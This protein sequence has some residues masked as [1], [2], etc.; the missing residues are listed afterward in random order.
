[1]DA[2]FSDTFN[3]NDAEF[4]Q[5]YSVKLLN[6]VKLAEGNP[7]LAQRTLS[8]FKDICPGKN[9]QEIKEFIQNNADTIDD[10]KPKSTAKR[11]TNTNQAKT[12]D[13]D[14]EVLFD[15]KK[16]YTPECTKSQH[17]MA[18]NFDP[19]LFNKPPSKSPW[20]RLWDKQVRIDKNEKQVKFLLDDI[21]PHYISSQMR[22]INKINKYT[23]AEREQLKSDL[24][25]TPSELF[26]LYKKI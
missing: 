3:F 1:M 9:I 18:L 15:G 22:K 23:Y 17:A 26:N 8:F 21:F 25:Q 12:F 14:P 16:I 11:L 19:A 7:E 10:Y 20:R 6:I 13:I 2:V 24:P 5:K 4:G